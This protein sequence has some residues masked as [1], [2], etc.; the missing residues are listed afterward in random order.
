MSHTNLVWQLDPTRVLLAA[1][2]RFE[3]AVKFVDH[4]AVQPLGIGSRQ[5]HL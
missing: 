4:T 5:R 1:A 2:Y 3:A